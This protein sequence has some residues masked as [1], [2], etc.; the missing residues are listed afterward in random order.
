MQLSDW[1]PEN[2]ENLLWMAAGMLFKYDYGMNQMSK[3]HAFPRDAVGLR[4]DDMPW[5]STLINGRG[6]HEPAELELH[7]SKLP[8]ER[9]IIQANKTVVKLRLINV[10]I[11][12]ALRVSVDGHRLKAVASDGYPFDPVLIDELFVQPGERFDVLL[13][14]V[15]F[16]QQHYKIRVKHAAELD[17]YGNDTKE[18]RQH[19]ALAVLSY[20]G[21]ALPERILDHQS[22]CTATSQCIVLSCPFSAY[23]V[24]K[25]RTCIHIDELHAS[26][27]C[28]ETDALSKT[29][30][31]SYFMNLRVENYSSVINGMKFERPLYPPFFFSDNVNHAIPNRCDGKC[32]YNGTCH[33]TNVINFL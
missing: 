11:E 23:P 24:T 18:I 5:F 1:Y 2:A 13:S 10:G 8:L 33:C 31:L 6:W 28:S 7:S 26:Q 17:P 30:T 21:G 32:S 15:D 29:P 4:L 25:N 20:E 14:R 22:N 27:S 3:C 12:K 9:F 19:F 16:S